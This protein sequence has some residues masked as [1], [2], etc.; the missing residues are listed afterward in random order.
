MNQI[1]PIYHLTLNSDWQTALGVGIYRGNTLETEHFIHCSTRAQV[2]EVA[3]RI[4]AAR[5]DLLLL[6]LNP[7]CVVPEIRWELAENG[8]TYPH[9]YGPLNIDAVTRVWT[10]TLSPAGYFTWSDQIGGTK[11]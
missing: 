8:E 1:E 10:L 3:N 7:A 9:I 5:T 4:F 6:E 2:L 11:P